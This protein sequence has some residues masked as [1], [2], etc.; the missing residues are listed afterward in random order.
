VRPRRL[1]AR[2]LRVDALRHG[3]LPT[4]LLLARS[5]CGRAG[6][7]IKAW[8]L[9]WPALRPSAGYESAS[10]HIEPRVRALTRGCC[11]SGVFAARSVQTRSEFS[12]AGRR[13]RPSQVAGAPW[14]AGRHASAFQPART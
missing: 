13:G 2:R 7:R 10:A 8:R 6:T 5:R 12:R 4:A 1:N 14:R 9:R 3:L 11:S